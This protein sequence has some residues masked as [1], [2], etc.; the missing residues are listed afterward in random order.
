MRVRILIGALTCFAGTLLPA[1]N[2]EAAG[3]LSRLFHHVGNTRPPQPATAVCNYYGY[4]YDGSGQLKYGILTRMS[5]GTTVVA[6]SVPRA[7]A[8]ES[9]PELEALRQL[10]LQLQANL[11]VVNGTATTADKK[12]TAADTKATTAD[13]KAVEFKN[14]LEKKL[15]TKVDK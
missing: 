14:E 7:V 15:D 13:A 6:Q 4:Y 12:A 9:D 11:G 10:V 5:D 3:P 2:V 1:S 8:P